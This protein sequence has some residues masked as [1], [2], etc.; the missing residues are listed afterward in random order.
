MNNLL[1][2]KYSPFLTLILGGIGAGLRGLLYALT[3]DG[4][5]LISV[6]HPLEIG[7]WAVT[8]AAAIL[9]TVLI[10][11]LRNAENNPN[12]F[13]PSLPAA[14][15]SAAA[16][17][18]IGLSVLSDGSIG[19]TLGLIRTVLGIAAAL[20]LLAVALCRFR[21]KMPFFGFHTV[22][23]VFFAVQL[24][25]CY[26]GWSSNPQLMDYVFSLLACVGLM[27]FAFYHGCLETGM[28]K[29]RLLPATGLL[30]AYCCMVALSGAEHWL[31]YLGG[32]IW[33]LTNLCHL[34]TEE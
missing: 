2:S 16:A 30:S 4:K 3:T 5:N 20:S 23:C 27:L 6:G 14:L 26:R 1:N 24:V 18:G 28:G 10:L 8:A 12:R 25:S 32:G 7:L 21:G 9:I 11:P 15:G 22:V 33:T 17:L 31:L 19:G 13:R 34:H 29:L